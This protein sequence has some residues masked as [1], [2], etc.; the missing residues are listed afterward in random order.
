M[1]ACP[2]GAA[3]CRQYADREGDGPPPTTCRGAPWRF[4]VRVIQPAAFGA[5]SGPPAGGPYVNAACAAAS[6][7]IGSRYGEQET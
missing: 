5:V 1:D 6:R 4:R 3:A 2:Q 7:A